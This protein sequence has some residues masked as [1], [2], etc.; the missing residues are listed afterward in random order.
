MRD[1]V[2]ILEYVNNLSFQEINR[3]QKILKEE[4]SVEQH[5]AE[6]LPTNI[7]CN[8]FSAYPGNLCQVSQSLKRKTNSYFKEQNKLRQKFYKHK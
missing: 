2:A 6:V 3:L 4:Y 7:E 5:A 8:S 1:K